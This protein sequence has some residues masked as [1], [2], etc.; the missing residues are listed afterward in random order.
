M[1][2]SRICRV[3][4]TFSKKKFVAD[5]EV[6]N[7][8]FQMNRALSKVIIGNLEKTTRT[9]IGGGSSSCNSNKCP[10]KYYFSACCYFTI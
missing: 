4:T 7:I 1:A 3:E 5:I 8:K 2:L 10:V 6:I 9:V